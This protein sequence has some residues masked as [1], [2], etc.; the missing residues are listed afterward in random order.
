MADI[1]S[2][3]PE[4]FTAGDLVQWKRPASSLV[5]PDGSTASA[6]EGWTLSYVLVKSGA[7]ITISAEASGEDHLVTL[8]AATTAA[9]TPGVYTWQAYATKSSARHTVGGGTI[10]IK[11]NFAAATST[12][13]DGRS[14]VKRVLDALEAKL[15]NRA[16]REQEQMI[17]SGE[18]IGMMPIARLLEWYQRY[19]AAYA[20]ELAS[21][22]VSAGLG[23]GKKILVRF[24][25]A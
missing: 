22:R 18:V 24:S 2:R 20:E 14:H 5:L 8:A 23:T 11:P 9:Y 7:K 15:E 25:D 16:T 21:A 19:K 3:E 6:A 10:E 1:P 13:Y 12:G 4:S 17:V